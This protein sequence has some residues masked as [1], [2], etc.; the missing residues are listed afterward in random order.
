MSSK[1][2]ENIEE[3]Y[4]KQNMTCTT[5]PTNARNLFHQQQCNHKLD[6]EH[7]GPYDILCGRSKACFNN[8]G[9][10]RFLVIVSLNLQRYLNAN[11]KHA[12]TK[13]IISIA[14]EL[15]DIGARFLK[16]NEMGRGYIEL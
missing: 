13:L 3:E 6:D 16:K 11:T 5:D 12:K 1:R 7:L 4:P 8:I 15:Y 10:R 14:R 9:N 2:K